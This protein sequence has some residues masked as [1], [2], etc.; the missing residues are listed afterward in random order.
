MLF[1]L[2]LQEHWRW[3]TV[4]GLYN[5]S[6]DGG[7]GSDEL[8][9][10]LSRKTATM[11]IAG[12]MRGASINQYSTRERITPPAAECVVCCRASVC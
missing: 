4:V 9:P 5:A 2:F 8:L 7:D 6:K 10:S 3:A 1:I 12:A 11:L